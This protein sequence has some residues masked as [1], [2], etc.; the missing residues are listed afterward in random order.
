MGVSF[1]RGYLLMV[2]FEGFKG[3]PKRTPPGPPPKKRH[4]KKG[5]STGEGAMIPSPS[6]TAFRIVGRLQGDSA[7][8]TFPTVYGSYYGDGHGGSH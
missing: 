5:S 8:V 4:P 3:N 7:W 2:V 1:L 6:A